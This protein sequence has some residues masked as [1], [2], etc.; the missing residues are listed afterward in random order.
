[1]TPELEKYYD[2]YSDLFLTDGWKQFQEEL[3][4]NAKQINSIEH[5]KDGDDLFFRKGQLSVLGQLLN[6]EDFIQSGRE[7]A[8]NAEEDTEALYGP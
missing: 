6:F 2:T 8:E 3:L 7:S 5:A 1:M 4:N